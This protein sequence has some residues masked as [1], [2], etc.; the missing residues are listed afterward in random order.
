MPH[1][2]VQTHLS[3][4]KALRLFLRGVLPFSFLGFMF[5]VP[6][7]VQDGKSPYPRTKSLDLTL[8]ASMFGAQGLF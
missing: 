7:R 8:K 3:G 2:H 5:K 6:T 1:E 4:R